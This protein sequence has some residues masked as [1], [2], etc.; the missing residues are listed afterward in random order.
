VITEPSFCFKQVPT[1]EMDI[2]TSITIPGGGQAK[3]TIQPH[4]PGCYKIRFIPPGAT[5]HNIPSS[6]CPEATPDFTIEFYSNYRVLP[7][8]DYSSY[9]DEQINNWPFMFE[10]VFGYYALF[11]PVMSTI[12]PWGPKNAPEDEERVREFAALMKYVVDE[13]LLK[14]PLA[15]PITREL[16]AG[17]RKLIQRWCDLQLQP[18]SDDSN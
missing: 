18:K 9:T 8:D 17:K 6:G 1:S 12:I 11:Y 13:K 10:H 2:P 16:S 5:K 7:T 14:S 4:A 3:L 15:M